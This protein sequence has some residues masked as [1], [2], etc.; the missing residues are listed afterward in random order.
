VRKLS[1][2]QRMRCE[3]AAALLHAP[4]LVFL[5]E[6][7]IGLD[8]VAKEAIRGFLAEE[9]REQGTTI[10]LTTH[11]LPDVERLCPRMLLIDRGRVVY[12][13]ALEAVR[14]RFGSER[15]L[16]VDFEGPAPRELP[17]GVVEEDRG[18]E[19]LVLRFDR[20]RIGSGRL[21]EWLTER[22]PIA[23]LSLEEPPI[24]R[25]VAEIYRRGLPEGPDPATGS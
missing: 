22:R 11:D 15:V 10:L 9:N 2:G 18:P 21:I 12:D 7:T 19:R 24:E 20:S 16:R 25:V 23:D 3:L 4:P 8:V 17:E 5:D 1:L 13:G 6:P 14:R